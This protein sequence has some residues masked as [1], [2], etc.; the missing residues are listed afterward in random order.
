ML[1]AWALFHTA[2]IAWLA[3]EAYI[4]LLGSWEGP[5]DRPLVL[6]AKSRPPTLEHE[7]YDGRIVAG[8]SL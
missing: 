4:S 1:D 5:I 7:A 2:G 3:M 6:G 8:G